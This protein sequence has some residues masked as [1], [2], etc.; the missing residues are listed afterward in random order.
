MF[1]TSIKKKTLEN[2]EEVMDSI[3]PILID[4]LAIKCCLSLISG[5]ICNLVR[6]PSLKFESK[7]TFFS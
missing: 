5:H 3:S 6:M 2:F 1:K 4:H 7:W